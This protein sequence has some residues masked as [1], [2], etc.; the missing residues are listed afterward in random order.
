MMEGLNPC[1]VCY[2][3]PCVI[4]EKHCVLQDLSFKHDCNN[5]ECFLNYDTICILDFYENCGAWKE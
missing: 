5:D 2:D 1:E 3:K 4:G